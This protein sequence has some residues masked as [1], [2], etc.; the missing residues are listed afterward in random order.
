[1]ATS[2]IRATDGTPLDVLRGKYAELAAKYQQ[3]VERVDQRAAQDLAIYRLGTWGLQATSAALAVIVSD[4]ITLVNARF[5]SL[6]RRLVGPLICIEPSGGPSH[7]DLRA[8]ALAE[9]GPLIEGRRP[10]S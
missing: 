3:L 5:T 2:E 9:A 1:M 8:L 10:A 7:P 4:R 6:A